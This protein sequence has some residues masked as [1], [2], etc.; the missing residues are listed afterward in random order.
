MFSYMS[1]CPRGITCDQYPWCIGPHCTGTPQ[2]LSH[3]LRHGTS[4]TTQS[5]RVDIEHQPYPLLVTYGGHH[6][7]PVQNCSLQDPPPPVLTSSDETGIVGVS[8]QY[9]SYWNAF[10][11][12]LNSTNGIATELQVS[13]WTVTNTNS[14]KDNFGK[15]MWLVGRLLPFIDELATIFLHS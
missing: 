9:G 1:V 4:G 2:A 15:W 8:G 6:W 10:L 3:P 12:H 7:R 11:F 13:S 14:G 5:Y